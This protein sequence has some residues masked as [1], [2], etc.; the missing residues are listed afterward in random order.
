MTFGEFIYPL[1]QGWDFWHLY[2]KLGVQLQIGGSDQ[3]GNIV[4]GIDYLKTVRETEEAPHLRHKAGL[5]YDPYGFTVPL[6]TDASGAKFGKTA[7]NALWLDAFKTTPFDLYGYMLR[8]PDTEVGRYLNLFTFLPS[9][10]IDEVMQVHKRNPAQRVAHHLLAFELLSLVHGT[11]VAV[12]EQSQH[13]MVFGKTDAESR[14]IIEKYQQEQAAAHQPVLDDAGEIVPPPMPAIVT[15]NN[16]PRMD[17]QLPRSVFFGENVSLAKIC[18]A[19][20]M[21]TSR[22]DAHRLIKSEGIYVAAAPGDQ[23]RALL[24]GNLDW[25]PAKLWFP[26]EIKRYIIDERVFILRRGKHHVRI[27]EIVPDEEY[28]KSGQKFP[29]M[30]GTGTVRTAIEEMRRAAA[31]EGVELSVQQ[32]RKKAMD[33][34]LIPSAGPGA[35]IRAAFKKEDQKAAKRPARAVRGKE[36]PRQRKDEEDD[37]DW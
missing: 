23:K 34:A 1:F 7:G 36:P 6:L 26:E 24:P 30:P 32:L 5:L 11:E 33:M 4:Q 20:G 15:P 8:R 9:H 21:T 13:M 29:G 18:Y 25:T 37:D 28:I 17:L 12:R 14:A 2:D 22:A 19:A 27:V 31:A 16:A 10:R 35:K 3:Y